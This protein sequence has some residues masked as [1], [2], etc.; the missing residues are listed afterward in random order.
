MNNFIELHDFSRRS[1]PKIL[2]NVN[3][4]TSVENYK[5]C[6]HHRKLDRKGRYED[7]FVEG[8]LWC[9]L[10]RGDGVMPEQFCDNGKRRESEDEE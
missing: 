8:C 9:M 10:G 3:H 1:H 7:S 4:I 2:I 6:I 5:D